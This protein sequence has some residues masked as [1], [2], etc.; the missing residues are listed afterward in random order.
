MTEGDRTARE[1]FIK[2]GTQIIYLV[3]AG[4]GGFCGSFDCLP[5]IASLK[6]LRSVQKVPSPE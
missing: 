5:S 2:G 3:V 4:R 1:P 6:L